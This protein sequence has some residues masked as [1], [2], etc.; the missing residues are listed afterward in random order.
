M[1]AVCPMYVSKNLTSFF[2][3]SYHTG[4]PE[5]GLLEGEAQLMMGQML[6]V[7]QV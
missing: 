3:C 7:L 4:D 6:K 2:D 1:C 5:K